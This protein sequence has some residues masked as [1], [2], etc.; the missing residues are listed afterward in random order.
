LCFYDERCNYYSKPILT[1]NK[2]IIQIITHSIDSKNV[3]GGYKT[4]DNLVINV[5]NVKPRLKTKTF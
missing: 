3:F 2:N 1:Y 4:L 5:I